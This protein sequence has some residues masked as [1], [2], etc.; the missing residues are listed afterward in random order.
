[1]ISELK[2]SKSVRQVL[3][4]L[5]VLEERLE[6]CQR[7]RGVPG[8]G[9]ASAPL[10]LEEGGSA[11]N[12][13]RE[14]RSGE[15]VEVGNAWWSGK[16]ARSWRRGGRGGRGGREGQDVVAREVAREAAREVDRGGP[17]GGPGL[18]GFSGPKKEKIKPKKPMR[19][20]FWSKIPAARLAGT[21]WLDLDDSGIELHEDELVELFS[22]PKK[23]QKQKAGASG[24][25]PKP[26]KV[27]VVSLLSGKRQQNAG[28]ALSSIRE[29]PSV[30]EDW[31]DALLHETDG[32][33]TAHITQTRAHKR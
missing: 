23:K 3:V 32:T 10:L 14:R 9:A 6:E 12:A 15:E 1:M 33:H 26:T 8:R 20:L 30:V 16:H 19:P 25:Q 7:S 27:K 22:K 5:V 13:W 24:S 28:I 18:G 17:R 4:P 21:V 31:L 2:C 11:C 29:E